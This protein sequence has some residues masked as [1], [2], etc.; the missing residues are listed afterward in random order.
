M[1][2]LTIV[3]ILCAVCKSLRNAQ[4][5]LRIESGVGPRSQVHSDA[6]SILCSGG[7]VRAGSHPGFQHASTDE[8]SQ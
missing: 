2:F 8:A 7:G 1:S 4:R 5:D 3:V 6:V